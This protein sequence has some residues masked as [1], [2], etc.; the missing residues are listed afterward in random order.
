MELL[1]ISF[2]IKIWIFYEDL[3]HFVQLTLQYWVLQRAQCATLAVLYLG[4]GGR[5]VKLLSEV[6]FNSTSRLGLRLYR[7]ENLFVG[8]DRMAGGGRGWGRGIIL[9]DLHVVFVGF[10]SAGHGACQ[11]N[12]WSCSHV[13]KQFYHSEKLHSLTSRPA[14]C[15]P[16]LRLNVRPFTES[17][18]GGDHQFNR[19]LTKG[20]CLRRPWKIDIKTFRTILDFLN[21]K[22][23]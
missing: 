6:S 7:F 13:I 11:R 14:A 5:R 21:K 23:N 4:A 3:L 9:L 1:A 2:K 15:I 20:T 17:F 22:L 12:Y 16:E 19:E 8:V 18:G 10:L